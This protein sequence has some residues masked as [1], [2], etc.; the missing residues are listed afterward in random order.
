MLQIVLVGVLLT[1]LLVACIVSNAQK[2]PKIEKKH[3]ELI[4]NGPLGDV[5]Q[6]K[7][8]PG[9]D[10]TVKM[11]SLDS[12]Y[13]KKNGKRLCPYCETLN[14]GGASNCCACGNQL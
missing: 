6:L 1:G 9:L 3:S 7:H 2:K 14:D 13:A 8:E 11:D 10:K 4:I 5:H 12:L